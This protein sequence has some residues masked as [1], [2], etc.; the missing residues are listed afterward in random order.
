MANDR[1]AVLKA[2]RAELA[3]IE[4]GAYHH[5]SHAPWRPQFI[6]QDSPTCLNRDPT[7]PRKPCSECVLAKFFP[8][9]PS[10]EHVPCSQIPLNQSGETIDSL[11]R[12]GTWE[13]LESALVGWLE[14]T[15]RRLDEEEAEEQRTCEHPVIHVTARFA[16]GRRSEPE[17]SALSACANPECR[18]SL[19]YGTG[20]FFR[21][22]QSYDVG[23]KP[24]NTHAVQ[25][26]W[27]CGACSQKFTLEFRE[28][29]G[30][31]LKNRPDVS[32]Q[33]EVLKCIAAA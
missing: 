13:E 17:H 14:K 22:R 15:I 6:F 25:H 19:A 27:L 1:S 9:A 33:P 23:N 12:T 4:S 10:M 3:F 7:K 21:F 5:P 28:G 16:S 2:L 32:S 18:L 11:Y 24:P 30:V 26:F 8:F 31:L 20:I 29:T